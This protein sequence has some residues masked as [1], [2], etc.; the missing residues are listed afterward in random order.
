M[1]ATRVSAAK[2]IYVALIKYNKLNEI[3]FSKNCFR[4]PGSG[5]LSFWRTGF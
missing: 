5:G 1:S 2:K 4:G 3:I